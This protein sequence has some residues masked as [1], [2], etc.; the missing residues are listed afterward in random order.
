MN[1]VETICIINDDDVYSYIIKKSIK[2]LALCNEVT[3][4]INGEDAIHSL[5]DCTN[6]LP[7]IIFLD[8]NMPVMDGWDFLKEF[9]ELKLN[10]TIPIYLTS[11]HVSDDDNLKA[12][13]SPLITAIIEDP[14]D[15][16]TLYKI[17]GNKVAR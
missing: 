15:T 2:K 14:T 4:F 5:K 16:E 6:K 11:A 3:T 7:D 9:E 10:K 17:T 1:K 12:I 8:I 13:S